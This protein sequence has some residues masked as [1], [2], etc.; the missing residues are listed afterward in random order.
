VGDHRWGATAG[1]ETIGEAGQTDGEGKRDGLGGQMEVPAQAA[2]GETVRPPTVKCGDRDQIIVARRLTTALWGP[3]KAW[4]RVRPDIRRWAK[5]KAKDGPADHLSTTNKVA[6]RGATKGVERD[7]G[8]MKAEESG[9]M[10]GAM[11]GAMISAEVPAAKGSAVILS[12]GIAFVATTA[13]LIMDLLLMVVEVV[14]IV[15]VIMVLA[16]V[17]AAVVVVVKRRVTVA[18]VAK[19]K[20]AR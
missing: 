17:V 4:A 12:A 8:V 5:D 9:A 1:R 14:V 15:Q 19:R 13:D 6:D 16:V 2:C 20:M 7:H 11:S 3:A 18:S 10:K